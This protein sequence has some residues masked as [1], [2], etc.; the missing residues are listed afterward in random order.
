MTRFMMTLTV[1]ILTVSTALVAGSPGMRG[2]DHIG[3]TVPDMTEAETFFVDVQR[4]EKTMSFGPF[5]D[6][7]GTLMQDLLEVD[8]RAVNEQIT[9]MRWGFSSN[10][11]L[12]EY[13]TPDQKTV[14]MH[15]SNIGGHHIANYVDNISAD[16]AYLKDKSLR[17]L[18]GPLTVNE[19][20]AAGQSI[21]YF[22]A[23]WGLQ[24]EEVSYPDGI[25]YEKDGST[26]LWA[27]HAPSK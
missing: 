26:V 17:S 15:N 10:T 8:P 6:D 21:M 16:A 13:N 14:A 24:M 2:V 12:F 9:L 5:H 27:S 18:M 25:A 7:E 23:P 22:F 1:G 11:E 19:G 3:L 4:C 20:P